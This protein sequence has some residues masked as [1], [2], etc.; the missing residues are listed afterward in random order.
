[1]LF[2]SLEFLL[3]F[4]VIVLLYFST[5]FRYRWMLLLAA[6]YYFYACWKIEY[7]LLLALSTLIDY[8]VALAMERIE[9]KE[10]RKPYLY[11]SLASNLGLLFVFKYADFAN[12]NL[13]LAFEQFNIFYNAPI[14][15]LLLPVGIS[16]Y[17]FQTLS[18]TIDVYRGKRNAERHL[19]IF[20]LYVSFFPQLVAGP[21]E[22]S[23]SL[24][25]QFH[26]EPEFR[27]L[28]VRQGSALILW[29]FFK[30]LVIADG[31]AVYVNAVYGD[32]ALF[33]FSAFMIATYLFMY[34]LY[35]DF[36]GY[37]DI[38]VGTAMIMGYR[39]SRNFD[40]PFAARTISEFWS[41][42]HISL[43]TWIRD[44]CYQPLIQMVKSRGSI[45]L[46]MLLVW[47]LFGLWH[48]AAWNYILFG[49]FSGSMIIIGHRT[50]HARR[51]ISNRFFAGSPRLHK[52]FQLF[53]I[54]HFM[55]SIALL[56][57][58]EQLSDLKI[59][60]GKLMEIGISG[61]TIL[62]DGFQLWEMRIVIAAI[63]FLEAV[64]W[65]RVNKP[66]LELDWH[67]WPRVARW[68]IYYLLIF[69]IIGFGE[70]NLT[71]FIYFQF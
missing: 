14:F 34:Q 2:N 38:A 48:G 69:T 32:P 12:E 22:R 28:D 33:S 23:T 44:Y 40:R 54:F 11:L 49:L 4:P 20:A 6:S 67:Q 66:K 27:W 55:F 62:I 16:F 45:V 60:A 58:L 13:R 26:K 64:Q 37:S 57:R 70:F 9:E 18:Y 39:L 53:I 15:D 25:P 47:M 52:A 36:S 41:R 61:Q 51:R 17:T 56:F 46:V 31:V 42:W 1:M 10:K 3:F 24:I 8:R 5:P 65:L 63:L 50:K 71:P 7:T 68:P 59:F 30:K 35:C 21:I 19:G 29:G 43:T